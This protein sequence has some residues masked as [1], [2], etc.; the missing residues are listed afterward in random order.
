MIFTIISISFIVLILIS[1]EFIKSSYWYQAKFEDALKFRNIP[2]D[3]QIV[4]LG[5][6]SGKYGFDYK[7]CD[8]KGMNWAVGPQ[9]IYFD[10][11]IL[12]TNIQN[13]ERHGIVIF[14]IVPFS[15]ILDKYQSNNANDKYYLFL[16]SESIPDYSILVKFNIE[17]GKIFPIWIFFISPKMLIRLYRT[18]KPNS[19]LE[20]NPMNETQLIKDSLGW[21]KGWQNQFSINKLT[22]PLSEYHKLIMQENRILLMQM[23]DLCFKNNLKPVIVLPPVTNYLLAHLT[24]EVRK[25]YVYD[26]L[27]EIIK[28]KG[29][30][31]FDYM[32]DDDFKNPDLYFNS[33]FLNTCGRILFTERVIRDI[34]SH[35][36]T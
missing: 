4:N 26:F 19:M 22:N 31:L 18:S 3:L 5:S 8:I 2:D 35:T 13:I 14:T 36:R 10:N 15:S 32:E 25:I 28:E 23:I 24:R 6:N 34:K 1:N 7:A 21:I 9:T 27:S 11:E 29:V 12:Q 33:F 17:L 30:K 16:A 20:H